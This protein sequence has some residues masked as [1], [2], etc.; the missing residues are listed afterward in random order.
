MIRHQ[1]RK[2][3]LL[4]NSSLVGYL[5]SLSNLVYWPLDE[6]SGTTA[7]AKY[8][9]VLNSAYDASNVNATVGQAGKGKIESSYD[10]LPANNAYVNMHSAALA[11]FFDGNVGSFFA[12][13]KVDNAAIWTDSSYHLIAGLVATSNEFIK[14]YIGNVANRL[15]IQ[16]RAESKDDIFQTTTIGGSTGWHFA[17]LTW[18]T[19]VEAVGYVDGETLWSPSTILGNWTLA[20]SSSL[21]GI[22]ADGPFPGTVTNKFDGKVAYMGVSDRVLTPTENLNIYQRSG[23]GY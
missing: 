16:R 23:I 5:D 8:N 22:G 1:K 4:N 11:S 14:F 7:L 17:L 19:G 18:D 6:Q 3:M 2:L 15:T 9:G 13:F 12:F 20:M 10:F 21:T